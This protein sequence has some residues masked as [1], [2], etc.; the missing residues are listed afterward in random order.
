MSTITKELKTLNSIM[1]SY[2][3]DFKA[4]KI[5]LNVTSGTPPA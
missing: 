4:I 3:S 2:K 1:L 5:A